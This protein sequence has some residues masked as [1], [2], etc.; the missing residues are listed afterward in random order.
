MST[1]SIN[2]TLKWHIKDTSYYIT[3]CKKV[4]DV[5]SGRVKKKCVNGGM[6]GYWIGR[7]FVS[8]KNMNSICE[9]VKKD[10]CPF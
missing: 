8:L 5:K 6:V 9:V 10:K 2:Y 1:I 7:K 3:T 4:V